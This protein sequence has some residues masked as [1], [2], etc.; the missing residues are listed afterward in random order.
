MIAQTGNTSFFN[1][2]NMPPTGRHEHRLLDAI[3]RFLLPVRHQGDPT[4]DYTAALAASFNNFGLSISYPAGMIFGRSDYAPDAGTEL[5][6]MGITITAAGG[7]IAQPPA[8]PT[9]FK[10]ITDGASHTI[11]I[12]EDAGRPA[13]T[14]TWAGSTPVRTR[15]AAALGPTR[16][17]TSPPTDRWTTAP[18]SSPAPAR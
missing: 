9:R 13:S 16:S 6:A 11:L 8:S 15:K 5:G 1:P 2:A 14:A 17:I 4:V 12:V 3:A 18:A 7:I 10:D